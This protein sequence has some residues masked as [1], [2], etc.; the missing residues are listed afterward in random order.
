[1]VRKSEFSNEAVIAFDRRDYAMELARSYVYAETDEERDEKAE[2][3]VSE[4][5][6]FGE[7]R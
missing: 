7:S 3:L 5:M 6:Y 4:I 1:M 2:R